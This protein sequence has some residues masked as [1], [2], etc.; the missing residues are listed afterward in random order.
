MCY[1]DYTVYPKI[2]SCKV[3]HHC[4]PEGAQKP[5]LLISETQAISFHHISPYSAHLSVPT[6]HMPPLICSSCRKTLST[7]FCIHKLTDA[8]DQQVLLWLMGKTWYVPPIQEPT[9]LMCLMVAF[10]SYDHC[11]WSSDNF[12]QFL[13]LCFITTSSSKSSLSCFSFPIIYFSDALQLNRA[14]VWNINGLLMDYEL[15]SQAV[16]QK[17]NLTRY[18]KKPRFIFIY[19][20]RSLFLNKILLA[21][22]WMFL[23]FFLRLYVLAWL[24]LQW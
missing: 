12:T 22:A 10:W 20:I 16:V 17:A 5:T 8:H 3:A 23:I 9:L 18:P 14:F 21:I 13:F 1:T 11:L 2:T 15:Q 7:L 6:Q 4:P 19:T 24:I